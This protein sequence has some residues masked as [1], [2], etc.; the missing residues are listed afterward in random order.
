MK[1][2]HLNIPAHR[3]ILKKLRTAVDY[4]IDLDKSK[5]RNTLMVKLTVY[6]LLISGSY[7]LILLSNHFIWHTMGYVILGFSTL[8]LAFNFA[9][10]LSHN[11]TFKNKSLN[12]FCY[13]LIYTLVGAHAESWKHRHVHSHHHAPN[14][15]DY[16][17]DLQITSLI[18]V[19]PTAP[20][21]WYHR[22][23]HLYALF[24]YATYSLYWIF[25]KDA[26][27]YA[28]V[29]RLG[30]LGYHVS[31]WCQKIFYLGYMLVVPILLS[32]FRLREIL[33]AFLIMHLLQSVFLLCTFFI[34]HHTGETKYF[35]TTD[36]GRIEASWLENQIGSS[37]DFY[38][39]S[40]IANFIF[41]GFNNH[42]AHH[43]FPDI[44]HVHYPEINKKIYPILKSYG[45]I[46]H[47]T[48]YLGGILAHLTHLKNM[49]KREK[50]SKVKTKKKKFC[51]LKTPTF[52]PGSLVDYYRSRPRVDVE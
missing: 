51:K 36:T 14:V 5:K 33:A 32:G 17:T 8:L 44:N 48:T 30:S 28:K 11:A 52:R 37:N 18:R 46:P 10:D 19:E 42:I 23:Q 3:E 1:N 47:Q 27:V 31:F 43:L 13:T 38:P 41:G 49:G 7:T 35:G 50:F 26:I 22:F 15:K 12:N 24:A 20:R 45:I 29:G 39:Y 21:R 9:H 4:E 2:R 16:D 40:R 6:L 25:V 34:T